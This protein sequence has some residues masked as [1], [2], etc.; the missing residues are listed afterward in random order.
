MQP[1]N[2]FRPLFVAGGEEATGAVD[3]RPSAASVASVVEVPRFPTNG[4]ST[5]SGAGVSAFAPPGLLYPEVAVFSQFDQI[6]PQMAL[7][8]PLQPLQA[9]VAHQ[10][11]SAGAEEQ[12]AVANR[13]SACRA[14]DARGSSDYASRHQAAEQRRRTRI[15]ERY[16]TASGHARTAGWPSLP[17]TAEPNGRD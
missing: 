10:Q 14:T 12:R 5:P 11:T 17:Q 13:T 16:V 1:G 15:N 3:N 7:L 4:M 9:P 6:L 2:V 8:H